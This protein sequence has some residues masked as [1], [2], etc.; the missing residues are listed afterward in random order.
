MDEKI[1]QWINNIREELDE[2]EPRFINTAYINVLLDKIEQNLK[3]KKSD[4]YRQTK[5]KSSVIT[6]S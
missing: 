4:N 3:P 6:V 5:G 2:V 1:E